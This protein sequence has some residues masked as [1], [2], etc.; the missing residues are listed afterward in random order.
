MSDA[1]PLPPFSCAVVPERDHVRVVPEGELDMAS[2][3]E[4]EQTIR[5]L[6]DAG[7]DH[8]VLD[9]RRLCFLD[10]TGLRLLLELSAAA[11]A[12]SHRLELIEG[13]PEVQRVIELTGTRS[14]LPFRDANGTG[15]SR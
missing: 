8:L 3:P 6:R 2:S 12:N 4:L 10:S 5:E 15:P 13:P 14:V 11:R 9:L 7:F 1:S